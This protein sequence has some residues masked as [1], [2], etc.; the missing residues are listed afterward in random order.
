V[1]T[2]VKRAFCT[3]GILAA[4]LMAGAASAAQLGSQFQ[5]PSVAGPAAQGG[6]T[7][8]AVVNE[9]IITVFDVQSRIQ[10]VIAT[11]GLE[12]TTDIQS[13]LLPQVID[14]L[15]EERLKMQEAARLKITTS[16]AELR[17]TVE[18][19][20]QR[21]NMPIGGFR[22]M[23]AEKGVDAS[24]LY[25]Q[26][27]ADLGWTKVVRESLQP[28]V[29]VS[30]DE[31]NA[32]LARVKANQGKEEF[33]V[34]EISLPV[35]SAAQDQVVRE[36][37]TRLVL[38]ARGGAPF[39]AL[40]QQ[41]S[42]SP[43]A[44]LGGDLGWVVRGDMEPELDGTLM[45]M[46]PNQISDPV[47]TATGYHILALRDRRISGAADPGMAIVTLSQIYLPTEG[48]RA[49]N[50]QRLAELS[51]TISGLKSCDEMNKLA[52]ELETPGSGPIP[53]IYSGALPEKIRDVVYQTQIGQT[54]PPIAV[55]G[56]RLFLQVCMRREDNGM[57]S[58]QQIMSNLE[59]DKL[60]NL[61]RQRLRDLRRQAL[62]DVRL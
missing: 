5:V 22:A 3:W 59:N 47:R 54:S 44:A 53:P 41:F 30:E 39:P 8:A 55:G 10:L 52:A 60:Q 42:Q 2:I 37:A 33:L 32:V 34:A 48:G 14:A 40:A 46:Q 12:N 31:I 19:I 61:A 35:T 20:E 29:K 7:I 24:A 26:I 23:L 49:L 9:E 50:P 21:N 15:I 28:T 11:S 38:Q 4:L 58:A 17:G 43:T 57:P 27:E 6:M 51:S 62:I 16:Q 56:A 18:Q 45:R 1:V 25:N 36:M 13:R